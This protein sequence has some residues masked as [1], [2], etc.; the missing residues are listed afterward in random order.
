MTSLNVVEWLY[1]V[2]WYLLILWAPL[3]GKRLSDLPRVFAAS[4]RKNPVSHMGSCVTWLGFAMIPMALSSDNIQSQWLAPIPIG[5]L[6]M[7]IGR[8]QRK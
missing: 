3:H 2:A 8:R 7:A 5:L 6:L 4:W 1:L